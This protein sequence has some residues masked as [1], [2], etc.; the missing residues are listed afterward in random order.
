MNR[1]VDFFEDVAKGYMSVSGPADI[2]LQE[3]AL[4]NCTLRFFPEVVR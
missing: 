2:G 3:E 4:F 1:A